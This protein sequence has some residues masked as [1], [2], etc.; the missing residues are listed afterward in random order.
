M[1]F[2]TAV[3]LA[4]RKPLHWSGGVVILHL[5]NDA[6]TVPRAKLNFVIGALICGACD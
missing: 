4:L 6:V 3:T 1:C 2:S 5:G